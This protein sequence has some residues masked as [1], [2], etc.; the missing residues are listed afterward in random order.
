M[1]QQ[2]RRKSCTLAA[3]VI[4]SMILLI[5]CRTPPEAIPAL[6]ITID[7]PEFPDPRGIVA[8]SPDESRVAMSIDYWILI[9]EYVL[10][11]RAVRAIREAT[12]GGPIEIVAGE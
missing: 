7:W 1:R 5:S 4:V 2:R 3:I 8:L 10:D 12:V 11:V 6:E 9:A